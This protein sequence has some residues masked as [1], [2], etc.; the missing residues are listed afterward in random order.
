MPPPEVT[1][2]DPTLETGEESTALAKLPGDATLDGMQALKGEALER[3]EAR[4]QVLATLRSS[5]IRATHPTDWLKF[6]APAEQGGQVVCYLDDA[7]CDRVRDLFGISVFAISKPEKIAGTKPG[8]FIYLVS[9]SGRSSVTGQRVEHMEGGRNSTDD[10]CKGVTGA[11]LELLVR[12]A[13]R[14]NLDGG[15]TRELAGMKSVPEEEL[16]RAWVGTP[17][18]TDQCRQGRGFGSRNERVGGTAPG[19]PTIAPPKCGVCKATAVFRTS[20]RGNFYGCPNYRNHADRKWTLD[21]ALWEKQQPAAAPPT[22]PAPGTPGVTPPAPA[23]PPPGT[24]CG[25]CG[26]TYSQHTHADHEFERRE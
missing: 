8:E 17:K 18:S 7:G 25:L 19:A 9:G 13:A 6:R 20:D 11:A 10:F 3:I 2:E 21:A 12:K 24:P 22:A 5:A 16:A 14:A 15:I 23:I 4:F 26:D 1:V